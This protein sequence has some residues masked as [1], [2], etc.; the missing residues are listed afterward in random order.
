[1]NGQPS[2]QKGEGNGDTPEWIKDADRDFAGFDRFRDVGQGQ[3]N[4]GE[5]LLGC[6]L[7]YAAGSIAGGRLA[8]I[9]QGSNS[10]M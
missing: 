5:V 3:G 6:I 10:S 8:A 9:C 2:N 7:V 4:T 1:V